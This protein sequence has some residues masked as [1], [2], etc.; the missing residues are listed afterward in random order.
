MRTLHIT[1]VGENHVLNCFEIFYDLLYLIVS[2]VYIFTYII[3]HVFSSLYIYIHTMYVTCLIE[4][5]NNVY[6]Y[7]D[8]PQGRTFAQSF[9]WGLVTLW[10]V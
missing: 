5:I 4:I 3:E 7:V 10:F 6:L 9:I 1:I 2:H 8:I